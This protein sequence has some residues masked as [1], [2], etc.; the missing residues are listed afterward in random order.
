MPASSSFENLGCIRSRKILYKPLGADVP[1]GT[2]MMYFVQTFSG[3]LFIAVAQ[4]VFQTRRK[5]E[6][7]E[8]M[9]DVDPNVVVSTGATSLQKFVSAQD[10]PRILSAYDAELTRA[11]LV[12]TKM[13]ALTL[14]GSLAVQWRTTKSS[15]SEATKHNMAINENVDT[16]GT[17][18]AMGD[19]P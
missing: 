4:N 19:A 10:L 18:A 3:A 14:I 16:E 11:F 1:T 9:P 17:A 13:A 8:T 12:A 7:I 5:E 15:K 6:L 2:P